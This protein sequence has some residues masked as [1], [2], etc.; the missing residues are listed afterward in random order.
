[1][2]TA[3]AALCSRQAFAPP[4]SLGGAA[5]SE[6]RVTCD[7]NK[8]AKLFTSGGANYWCCHY[9]NGSRRGGGNRNRCR[10]LR[11]VSTTANHA[12]HM[13]G[14]DEDGAMFY[15]GDEDEKL[16][17]DLARVLR[18]SLADD[19]SIGP[20]AEMFPICARSVIRNVLQAAEG[21]VERAAEMLSDMPLPEVRC[22]RGPIMSP[23]TF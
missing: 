12:G 16:D 6:Q 1:M 5:P 17:D 14:M 9:D 20:L 13:A 22:K 8:P 11:R 15:D 10:F 19:P 4:G 7:C 3:L 21:N 2:P 18:E 23:A